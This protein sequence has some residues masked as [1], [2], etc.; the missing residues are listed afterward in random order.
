MIPP[1]S[2]AQLRSTIYRSLSHLYGRRDESTDLFSEEIYV[3]LASQI[4]KL[5]SS[6]RIAHVSSLLEDFFAKQHEENPRL[7]DK[8]W[9]ERTR[10]LV[11]V[12]PSQGPNP[13][14]ESLYREGV[15]M[16]T[17]TEQVISSYLEADFKSNIRDLPDH[18]S[19]EF[20]FMSFLCHKESTLLSARGNDSLEKIRKFQ[21]DF[22]E[23]HILAW[24]PSY[25]D[26]LAS[27]S[28]YE[29][30]EVLSMLTSEFVLSEREKVLL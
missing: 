11:G 24:I 10:L 30:F 8:L 9:V 17:S 2:L 1:E 7:S 13:P 20:D 14:Y 21:S 28:K 3:D 27:Q 4:R 6:D 12:Q 18:I 5:R 15:L 25:C 23:R 26:V 16:G 22:L 29:I 19:I